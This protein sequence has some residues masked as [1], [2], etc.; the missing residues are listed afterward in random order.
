M[1]TPSKSPKKNQ[2]LKNSSSD[3]KSSSS[4]ESKLQNDVIKNSL[5]SEK[6]L[7]TSS[8][9]L[10]IKKDHNTESEKKSKKRPLC[11]FGSDCY[12]KN[13]S[14]LEEFYHPHRKDVH[15]KDIEAGPS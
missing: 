1:G 4:V 6:K 12:R 14:H 13:P 2:S 15:P 10:K 5:P 7:S 11:K 3:K 8:V 9:D